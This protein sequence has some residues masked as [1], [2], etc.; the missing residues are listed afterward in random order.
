[1]EIFGL[2]E[3]GVQ[4]YLFLKCNQKQTNEFIININTKKTTYYMPHINKYYCLNRPLTEL[5]IRPR[6]VKAKADEANPSGKD[7]R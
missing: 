2:D 7:A 6:I 5:Q 3:L 1:M 4:I